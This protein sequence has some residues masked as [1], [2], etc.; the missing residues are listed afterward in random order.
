[1][2]KLAVIV[3]GLFL[4]GAVWA[5]DQTA[6][7]AANVPPKGFKSLFNGKDLSGWRGLGHVNPYEIAKWSPEEKAARQ[8]EADADMRKH[9]RVENGEIINDGAGV[10]LTT[11]KDYRDF[12]LLVEWRMMTPNTDSGIYL[13][14]TPQ[15]QIWDPK[16]ESVKAAG[17]DRGSGALWNNSDG[18]PGKFPPAVA[19]KPVGEWN[20]FRIL[21]VG[22]RVSVWLNGTQTVDWA[23]MEN[24]WDRSKPMPPTG[25]IQLQTHGGEMRFR[26]VFIREIDAEE[27]NK[28]LQ[29]RGSEGFRN[30]FNGKDLEGWIGETD[31]YTAKDGVLTFTGKNHGGDI[32]LKDIYSDFAIR[33]EFKLPP[34]GNN[35]L[36]LRVPDTKRGGTFSGMEIQILDDGDPQYKT[37]KEWQF[38]GSVYGLA[39]AHKGYLRPVGQWNYQEVIV[40]GPR[41]QVFLNGTK[42]TDADLS[43][44]EKPLD[45]RPH[46][47][48]K[49]TDG[50]VG[51]MGHGDPVEFRNIRIKRLR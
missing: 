38:T 30:A 47:G 8:K 49:R 34:G 29:T 11:D 10:Y 24:F 43:K 33:F 44:I 20:T 31:K 9:W 5:A 7:R 18:A 28:M 13:R 4:S 1:M 6:D 2:R 19:D 21:M 40:D 22:E 3:A 12:E 17:A 27:A 51:F 48:M 23:V 15:V 37:I 36:L 39:A 45:D 35:G 25:P 46:P 16:N 32:F 26:N 14:G 41:I 42:I 50:Y